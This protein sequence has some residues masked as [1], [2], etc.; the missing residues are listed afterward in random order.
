MRISR[1]SMD[2]FGVFNGVTVEDLPPG[3]VLFL[4][5]NET[6]KSTVLGFVH[7][8]L[9]GYPDGRSSEKHY[10]PLN[11]GTAGG[12]L[13]LDTDS[14]GLATVER[15][16]GAKGGKVSITFNDGETGGAGAL[17]KILGGTNRK[18]FRNLYGFSLSE[19]QSIET[20]TNEDVR[21][22][23]YGASLGSGVRTLPEARKRLDRRMGELF[24]PRGSKP[25]INALLKSLEDTRKQ[26]KEA[27]KGVGEYETAGQEIAELTVAI[28]ATRE[29]L[30]EA[31][32]RQSR[33]DGLLQLW[34]DWVALQEAETRLDE[35]QD[36][37]ED[38]PDEG[39]AKLNDLNRS[40]TEQ[41]DEFQDTEG[42]LENKREELNSL[43]FD[44]ALL[45]QGAEIKGLVQ[46]LETYETSIQS[47]PAFK[48][49]VQ[50]RDADVAR[51]LTELGSG[52]TEE[53][54]LA[55]DRSAHVKEEIAS[56]KK[57]LT[58]WEARSTTLS[59]ELNSRTTAL[60]DARDDEKQV[61]E[62]VEKLEDAGLDIDRPTLDGLRNGRDQ[63]SSVLK[64]LPLREAEHANAS[65]AFTG[66]LREIDPDWTAQTL[67][68]L[69]VSIPA[70]QKIERFDRAIRETELA[71]HDARTGVKTAQ[72]VVEQIRRTLKEKQAP[73]EAGGGTVARTVDLEARRAR[74]RELRQAVR[75]R[76]V[77][78]G[79]LALAQQEQE[80]AA[81][82]AAAVAGPDVGRL[83]LFCAVSV[84]V[85]G[86]LAAGVLVGL[87]QAMAGGASA[88]L[89]VLLAAALMLVRRVF[90]GSRRSHVDPTGA[91]RRAEKLRDRVGEK[92]AAIDELRKQLGFSG[93]LD[94][95]TVDR[96]ADESDERLRD[97]QSIDELSARLA[98]SE[99]E[100][101]AAQVTWSKAQEKAA[102]TAKEW[103]EH[104]QALR[105]PADT[106]PRAAG[107]VFPKVEKARVDQRR[108][109]E[110]LVRIEAMKTTRAGY[111]KT[112]AKVP[113][114]AQLVDG[115]DDAILAGLGEFLAE[116][117]QQEERLRDLESAR[118]ALEDVER[119]TSVADRKREEAEADLAALQTKRLAAQDAW[120]Q[121]LE[122]HDMDPG[123]SPDTAG[124]ALDRVIRLAEITGDRE[125]AASDVARAEK[126]ARDYRQ[127]VANVFTTLDRP[128]PQERE[129]L[130]E[131][132]RLEEDRAEQET[133]RT[134]H[135]QLSSDIS[136]A[137][138]RCSIRRQ[139]LQQAETER[140][141]LI[142]SGDAKGE[143]EFRRR[144]KADEELRD[145]RTRIATH[146]SAIKKVAGTP[147]LPAL[148]DE[149]TGESRDRL[150]AEK[151]ELSDR[152][153]ELEA[154]QD[155]SLQKRGAAE[156]H[157]QALDSEDRV[158]R[159]RTEEEGLL[160][161][162]AVAAR[163]WARHAVASY[164]LDTAKDRH[165]QANQ[166]RVIRE[167]CTYFETITR[168]RYTK[169]F[170]PPG[171]NSMQVTDRDGRSKEAENLSRGSMEQLYLAIRFGYISAQ[172]TDTEALP[173]LMDD[174]LVN[175]DPTRTA[176]AVGGI[177]QMAKHRQVL[178]FT[179]HPTVVEV[180]REQAPG[181]PVHVIGGGKI[182]RRDT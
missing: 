154:A 99:K 122:E 92:N 33:V 127:R 87:D 171:G 18:L 28:H 116:I 104:V 134:R 93:A 65:T 181:V 146:E 161:D 147:D 76:D 143:E 36:R 175:F 38:F 114:L 89:A 7:T 145:L 109:D 84:A 112:M 120:K 13:V 139:R 34:E 137:E 19:L 78:E 50:Q 128:S 179:C 59:A 90:T 11:G 125:S 100:L 149:L 80:M 152:V 98:Q 24:T 148:R 82:G 150:V 156:N 60:G 182:S 29:K 110:L 32:E 47:I 96:L 176:A 56:H 123:W 75:D 2:G 144:G 105:L 103:A 52:W 167:A 15:R 118:S 106:S 83:L 131:I 74:T 133:R 40:I 71:V 91:A 61:R 58:R 37:V 119:R 67:G 53:R 155:D 70:Q 124:H 159:L 21:D 63:F 107:L 54:A 166:P 35:L 27:R 1:L 174:V 142:E 41:R 55:L 44:E 129:L 9:F 165:A 12:R 81:A 168:G 117:G 17:E 72:A 42:V 14:H 30:R 51:G 57:T 169:V 180:F 102:S 69:D 162:L 132:R 66:T 39:L 26:L 10:P 5:D 43:S 164:L 130:V 22:V 25:R 79:R 170:A 85:V 95:A 64:D 173:I 23:I 153:D 101:N 68:E 178:F 113:R 163:D 46:S 151:D 16:E 157:R 88:T 158:A 97:A 3:L 45:H 77:A 140:N 135:E 126:V 177:L 4:G 73:L 8:V 172:S 94:L 20:L 6:G 121:W 48:S 141:E 111:L 31:R 62:R 136:E 115:K 49:R 108:A 86:L 160:E 138:A